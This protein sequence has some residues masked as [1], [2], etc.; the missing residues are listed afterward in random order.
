MLLPLLAKDSLFLFS[1]K[2][3]QLEGTEDCDWDTK[4]EID[5][6]HFRGFEM[7]I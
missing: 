3:G 7:S 2:L 6:T 5:I 1:C 4:A